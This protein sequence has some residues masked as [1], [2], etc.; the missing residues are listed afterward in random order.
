VSTS[1]PGGH[2][3]QSRCGPTGGRQITL[4]AILPPWQKNYTSDDYTDYTWHCPAAP[5]LCR[6]RDAGVTAAGLSIS[7]LGV[8]T[9]SGVF[10]ATIDPTILAAARAIAGSPVGL[11]TDPQPLAAAQAEFRERT[12]GGVGGAKWLATLLPKDFRAPIHYRWP[13]YVSTPRGTEWRP[14]RGAGRPDSC[15]PQTGVGQQ[16]TYHDACWE[17]SRSK[18]E[19]RLKRVRATQ[20][21]RHAPVQ[22]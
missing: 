1:D 20:R 19:R 3:I 17:R 13:E 4:T 12:G 7:D 2:L 16:D 10:P 18:R 5:P 6:A 15:P 14:P 9:R 8:E 22:R 21:L 11:M